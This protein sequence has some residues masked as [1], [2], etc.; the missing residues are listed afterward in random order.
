MNNFDDKKFRAIVKALRQMVRC[1]HC[2]GTFSEKDI[3]MVSN[4]GPLY[5]VKMSCGRCGLKVI[6]SLTQIE[7][8]GAKTRVDFSDQVAIDKSTS[9]VDPK[10]SGEEITSN[11]M[12]D[13]HEFLD[14]FDGNFKKIFE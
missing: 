8:N 1:P 11:D 5:A 10:Y 14:G 13:L 6:A 3:E 2:S 7:N 12:I 4:L 9:K